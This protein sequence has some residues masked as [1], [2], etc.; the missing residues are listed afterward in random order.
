MIK[1]SQYWVIAVVFFG[2]ASLA[3]AASN[4]GSLCTQNLKGIFGQTVQVKTLFPYIRLQSKKEGMFNVFSD[5]QYSDGHSF[6]KQTIFV[7]EFFY[8]VIGKGL[9]AQSVVAG[10]LCPCVLVCVRHQDQDRA[11]IFHYN[12]GSGLHEIVDVIY[13]EFGK[14]FDKKKLTF[15][16]FT[17]ALCEVGQATHEISVDDQKEFF[18]RLVLGLLIAFELPF[19]HAKKTF[20]DQGNSLQDGDEAGVFRNIDRTIFVDKDLNFRSTAIFNEQLFGSA[21]ISDANLEGY[22]KGVYYDRVLDFYLNSLFRD[23]KGRIINKSLVSVL[24][25]N[26]KMPFLRIPDAQAGL[27]WLPMIGS[28][29]VT[30]IQE[31]EELQQKT[32]TLTELGKSLLEKYSS[33][34]KA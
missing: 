33:K 3:Q 11:I 7:P 27:Q 20:S 6:N 24:M 14:K 28:G 9:E 4:T 29:S 15:N 1:H 5:L 25:N 34:S 23:K 22:C 32:F 17:K 2:L 19:D 16:F 12:R 30:S 18:D 10:P 21:V 31:F 13:K 8:A 26:E